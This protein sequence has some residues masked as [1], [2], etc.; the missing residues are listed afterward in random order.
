M[1]RYQGRAVSHTLP[2]ATGG[3][4]RFK[5]DKKMRAIRKRT[6]TSYGQATRRRDHGLQTAS[7]HCAFA[8]VSTRHED[9][10]GVGDDENEHRRGKSLPRDFHKSRHVFLIPRRAVRQTG[11]R[12]R[13]T[14][15]PRDVH[16]LVNT[17][18]GR[19]HAAK[20]GL[21]VEKLR[22]RSP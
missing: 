12:T 19:Q 2:C 7:S 6:R 21:G 22:G 4:L 3:F 9:E 13:L 5:R 8:L 10:D 1:L 17:F 16:Y 15:A 18:L 11:K 14:Q 20:N